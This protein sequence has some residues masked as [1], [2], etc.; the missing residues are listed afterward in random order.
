MVE[1]RKGEEGREEEKKEKEKEKRRRREDGGEERKKEGKEFLG[2]R[3]VAQKIFSSLRK[4]LM[5]IKV[6]FFLSSTFPSLPQ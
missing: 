2:V 4:K 5:T 1:K 3:T 6:I